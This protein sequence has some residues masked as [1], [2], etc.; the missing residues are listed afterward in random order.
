MRIR[1]ATLSRFLLTTIACLSLL[2]G[3]VAADV[4][5]PGDPTL[6]QRATQ[7][8]TQGDLDAAVSLFA[9]WLEADPNQPVDWYNFACALALSGESGRAIEALHNAVAAGYHDTEWTSQDSDLDSLREIPEFAELLREM[10]RLS[11]EEGRTQDQ[12]QHIPQ[13]RLGSYVLRLPSG[14]TEADVTLHPLIVLLHGRGG[15]P[16]SFAGMVE[17]LSLPDVIYALPQAPYPLPSQ[18]GGFQYWPEELRADPSGP[19]RVTASRLEAQWLRD[20][21]HDVASN[22]PVDTTKVFLVGFSQGAAMTY[23]A[24]LEHPDVYAGIAPLGGWIPDSHRDPDRMKALAANG[25]SLFIGHGDRD[26]SVRPEEAE[27]ARRLASEAGIEHRLMTYPVGHEISDPMTAD[28][29][30]WIEEVCG[31]NR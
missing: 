1:L 19:E 29:R 22:Q 7:A 30:K 15:N 10:G 8:L 14:T 20:L 17:R 5:K 27:V 21:V 28:L 4:A 12:I 2:L 26:A 11:E 6:G 9:R 23:V 24:A 31:R 18:P 3:S 13:H 25:V 16:E